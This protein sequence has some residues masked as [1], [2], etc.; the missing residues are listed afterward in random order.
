MP[1]PNVAELD[2]AR[3]RSLLGP[4]G[5]APIRAGTVAEAWFGQVV[6][7]ASVEHFARVLESAGLVRRDDHRRDRLWVLGVQETHLFPEEAE[8]EELLKQ[9]NPKG[10]LLAFCMRRRVEPPV[11]E[12]R[13]QGAFYEARMSLC[14]EGRTLDSGPQRAASKKT[15]EQLAARALLER[16]ASCDA[17]QQVLRIDAADAARLQAS[18]PKGRLLEWCAQRNTSAPRFEQD[19]SPEGYRI[20]AVVAL[21]DRDPIVT[22]WHEAAKLKPAEQA[23]A[24]AALRQLPDEPAAET[25]PAAAGTAAPSATS[26][27]ASSDRDAAATLNELTQAGLLQAVGYELLGQSGPSHQP[28]FAGLAWAAIADG[29]TLR[30]EPVTAPSKKAGQRQA[31]GRLVDLL[32]QEGLTRG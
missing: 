9:A 5:S 10:Q 11:A 16:V 30:T 13:T 3:A 15:A 18:N 20:R 29:R 1:V 21:P 22:A 12:V 31:A 6:E 17:E 8:L 26:P 4:P 27:P 25:L 28:T 23:A 7:R 24:E 2:I 14:Y 32:I 19:V